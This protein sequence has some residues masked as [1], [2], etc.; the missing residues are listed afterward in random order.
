MKSLCRID[1]SH[2]SLV[3]Y[4]SDNTTFERKRNVYWFIPLFNEHVDHFLCVQSVPWHQSLKINRQSL[5]SGRCSLWEKS[6]SENRLIMY[7]DKRHNSSAAM[8]W[9]AGQ[10]WPERLLRGR[11]SLWVLIEKVGDFLCR[12]AEEKTVCQTITYEEWISSEK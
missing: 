4:H 12:Q 11:W 5:S 8:A 9:R 7:C 2:T 10:N 3:K 6:K 1:L